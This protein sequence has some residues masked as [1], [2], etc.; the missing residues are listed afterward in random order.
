MDR[1]AV[2]GEA[3]STLDVVVS[4]FEC[5]GVE[6]AIAPHCVEATTTLSDKPYLLAVLCVKKVE[7]EEVKA[8][9]RLLNAS[10]DIPIVLAMP[11][12]SLEMALQAI[13]LGAFDL[14]ILPTTTETIK[15]LL[16]R[17]RAL[18]QGRVLRRLT[19]ASQ[20]SRWFAHEVRNPLS[21]I[22]TSAQL[23]IEGS[24]GSA[25]LTTG[26]S[27]PAQ[28]YLKIIVE[29]CNRLEQFLKSL[30]EVGRSSRGPVVPADLNGVAERALTRA[31]PQLMAQG[32]RLQR[33]FDSQLP[34]VRIDVA[35]VDLAVFRMIAVAT[36]AMPTG[37]VMTV[38]TRL[39][40]GEVMIELEVTDTALGVGAERERQLFD[41]RVPAMLQ[42]A[43]AGLAFALQTFAEHGGDMSVHTYSGAGC[44]ILARLPLSGR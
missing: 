12:S 34:E 6:T 32:I 2:L 42:G 30:T 7:G 11:P 14:L 38:V 19:A 36:E 39:R 13:R 33:S 27:D 35:R 23:S 21:V 44:G 37:G 31:V 3:G 15:D 22:L 4:A 26:S 28:R 10:L 24:A 17:A 20:L 40:P 5:Q 29:E 25:M 9:L 1:V 16:I 41:P 43:E 18:R 8:L